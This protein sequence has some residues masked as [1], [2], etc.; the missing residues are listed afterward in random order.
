VVRGAAVKGLEGDVNTAV[1]IRKCRRH[2]GTSYSSLFQKG[3]HRA[4][5]AYI[6]PFTGDKRASNQMD[7]LLRKG[8]D[9]PTSSA[10][11][12][13]LTFSM[14]FWVSESRTATVELLA[15]NG[16]QEPRFS[17]EAVSTHQQRSCDVKY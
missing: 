9:L 12:G 16:D 13:T 3:K 10:K 1:K 5:D 11:H 2:Y 17:D 15:A 8:Q 14:N 4:K 7:W 6:C